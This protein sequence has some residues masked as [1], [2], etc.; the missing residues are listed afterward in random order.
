[1]HFLTEMSHY[2]LFIKGAHILLQLNPK[3]SSNSS[4]IKPIIIHIMS[5]VFLK[6][7]ASFSACFLNLLLFTLVKNN[8]KVVT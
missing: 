1:M 7:Q 2:H 3:Q 6:E 4:F 5:P 8:F